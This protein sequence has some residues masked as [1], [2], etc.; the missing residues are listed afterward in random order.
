ML[1][2]DAY[3]KIKGRRITVPPSPPFPAPL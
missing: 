2:D 1:D 3:R